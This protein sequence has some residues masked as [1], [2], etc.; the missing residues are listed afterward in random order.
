MTPAEKAVIRAAKQW[1]KK[2]GELY[3]TNPPQV[4]SQLFRAVS[5][6]LREEAKRR[7]K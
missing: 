5:I 6:L 7:K 2:M 3:W 4:Y 1:A